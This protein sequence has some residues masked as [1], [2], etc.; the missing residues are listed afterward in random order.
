MYAAQNRIFTKMFH[1]EVA[2]FGQGNLKCEMGIGNW[3]SSVILTVVLPSHLVSISWYCQPLGCGTLEAN[4]NRIDSSDRLPS[5]S[6]EL[7]P[8]LVVVRDY[9]QF[10]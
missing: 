9:L 5:K 2:Y 10:L 3:K 4:L 1:V 6:E 8:P 7:F